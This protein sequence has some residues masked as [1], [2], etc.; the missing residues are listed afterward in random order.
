VADEPSFEA[1]YAKAQSTPFDDQDRTAINEAIRDVFARMD[2]DHSDIDRLNR[3]FNNGVRRFISRFCSTL[4]TTGYFF[5]VNQDLLVERIY[6][7][8]VTAPTLYMPGIEPP[9]GERTFGAW[10]WPIGSATVAFDPSRP[11]NL[12]RQFNY[13]KLHGSSN[14]RVPGGP[15]PMV[16]GTGKEAQISGNPL[17]AWYFETFARVLHAGD[18]RLM[19]IGY[20]F[21]DDHINTAIRSAVKTAGLELFVWNAN[22]NPLDTARSALGADVI[23]SF[24]TT[25]LSEMFPPDQSVPAELGRIT[26][27]FFGA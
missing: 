3:I 1:A 17:L 8:P 27:V 19:T 12:E 24:A 5:T 18:T 15:T 16:I 9:R 14:W 26:Q 7:P 10:N 6:M 23:P 4:N 25:P 13:I 21:G 20:G 2:R 11:P 22:S